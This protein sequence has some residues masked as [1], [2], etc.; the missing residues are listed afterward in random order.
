MPANALYSATGRWYNAVTRC[1]FYTRA[2]GDQGPDAD[3]DRTLSYRVSRASQDADGLVFALLTRSP[4]GA[5]AETRWLGQ[6]AVLSSAPR[7]GDPR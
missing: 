3:S 7:L 5:S 4:A 2:R 6:N 1:R